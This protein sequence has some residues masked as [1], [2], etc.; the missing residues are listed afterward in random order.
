MIAGAAAGGDVGGRRR[1]TADGR[2]VKLRRADICMVW[3]MVL[4]DVER[5]RLG[6]EEIV[7]DKGHVAIHAEGAENG[8]RALVDDDAEKINAPKARMM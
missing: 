3:P 4:E 5:L 7:V 1:P 8:G 6:E 2:G